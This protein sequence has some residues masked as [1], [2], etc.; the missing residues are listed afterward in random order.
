MIVGIVV[1]VI[2]LIVIIVILIFI[3]VIKKDKSSYSTDESV[4]EIDENNSTTVNGM[5]TISDP[6]SIDSNASND[7]DNIENDYDYF[8]EL[9]FPKI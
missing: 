5:P 1:V 8:E 4:F 3:F 7:V 6:N 9:A 2:V